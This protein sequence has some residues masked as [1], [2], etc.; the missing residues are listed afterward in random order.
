LLL[1]LAG[2]AIS[3]DAAAE[4]PEGTSEAAASPRRETTVGIGY[5]AIA[6]F[7]I[8]VGYDAADIPL[9]SAT[10]EGYSLEVTR[11]FHPQLE[12][13]LVA[14]LAGSSADG[15]GGYAHGLSRF[16]GEIRFLP[17]GFS[18]VEP[19]IGAS[20]GFVLAD[21]YATWDATPKTGPHAVSLTRLGHVE[22]LT[23][24]A[25]L[26]LS[27]GIAIGARGGLLLVGF[28]KASVEQE[29][30]DTTGAYLIHPTDYRTRPWYSVMLSAEVTVID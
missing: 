3:G 13:G 4:L 19:W 9:S 27:S 21:D 14:W 5:A 22:E 6:P 16:V 28:P 25:R 12:C 2:A 24:G 10:F 15:R 17:L 8:P 11:R 1:C 23:A 30:G 29:P 7:K 18:R 20:L 26:R